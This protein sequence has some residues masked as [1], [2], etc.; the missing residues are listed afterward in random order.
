M[1]LVHMAI[2][3]VVGTAFMSLVMTMISR[4]GWANAI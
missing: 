3:G 1:I 4:G 2:A